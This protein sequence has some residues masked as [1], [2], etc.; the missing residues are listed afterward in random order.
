M[1]FPTVSVTG[2]LVS[3]DPQVSIVVELVQGFT[4]RS[5]ARLRIRFTNESDGSRE[6]HFGSVLPFGPFVSRGN[7]PGKIHVLPYDVD[8]PGLREYARAIPNSTEDGCWH[9]ATEYTILES[10]LIWQAD[11]GETT[12]GIYVVLNDQENDECLPEGEY[13]FENEWGEKIGVDDYAWYPWGFTLSL[14]R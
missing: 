2:D 13:R 1:A 8:G 11:P 4:A 6:F 10:G 5:P 14:E 7:G 3:S 12:A 9:L